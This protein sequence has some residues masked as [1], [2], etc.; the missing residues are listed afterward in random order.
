MSQ[1]IG[2]LCTLTTLLAAALGMRGRTT[3][4]LAG[5]GDGASNG[6]G[7]LECRGG[8]IWNPGAGQMPCPQCTPQGRWA[9]NLDAPAP[10]SCPAWCA[11]DHVLEGEHVGTVRTHTSAADGR[12]V[13]VQLRWDGAGLARLALAVTVEA[14]HCE[15]VETELDL[16]TAER[17][18]LD[19]LIL[20]RLARIGS[21]VG[22]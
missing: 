3:I 2:A 18:A 17:L 14:G 22:R 19:L 1:L 4:A 21:E 15:A 20:A 8:Y 11:G 16:E 9:M 12:D 10:A 5:N 13:C 7:L 6:C